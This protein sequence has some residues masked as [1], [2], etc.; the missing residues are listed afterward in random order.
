[1]D[2]K[3]EFKRLQ[4]K[5]RILTVSRIEAIFVIFWER[6]LL[7]FDLALRICL[8]DKLKI[9]WL[10]FSEDEISRKTRIFILFY[11]FVITLMWV[12]NEREDVS[13]NV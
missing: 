13:E 1:M 10:M 8:E 7:I 5:G 6:I 4:R 3:V 2:V 11:A 12:Y 9:K